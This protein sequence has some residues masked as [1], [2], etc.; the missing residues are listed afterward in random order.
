MMRKTVAIALVLILCLSAVFCGCAPRYD[1]SPDKVEGIR[2]I[3]YDYSFCINPADDCKGYY[4]FGDTKYNIQVKFESSR[5]TAVDTDKSDTELF[6][7]DWTYEKDNSG[8]EQLYLY[9][10]RFNKDDYE[11]LE[12]DYAE[13]VTLKQ[14][15]I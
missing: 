11:E 4:K 10:I 13:F 9:N 12:K 2:W 14:E 6:N 5:F 15:E 8:K 7:G 3:T 1:T